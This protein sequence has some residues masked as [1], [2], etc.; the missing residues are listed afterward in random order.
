MGPL[1]LFKTPAIILLSAACGQGKSYMIKYLMH[2]LTQKTDNFDFG[3]CISNTSAF[4]GEY[5]YIP[6][7]YV[8][9]L[10]SEKLIEN[11]M[12]IQKKNLKSRAFLILDDCLGQVNFN[13]SAILRLFTQYRHFRITILL[14]TQYLNKIP[15]FI[16]ECSTYVFI[17]KQTIKRSY[18]SLYQSFGQNYETLNKF[19]KYIQENTENYNTVFVDVKNNNSKKVK[20]KKC[21]NYYIDFYKF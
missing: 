8:H 6:K 2:N 7:K 13:N 20:A 4:T 19:I 15:T 21:P 18:E 10:Y 14:S 17:F 16:R 1:K 5:D 11:L 3:I 9:S 12:N